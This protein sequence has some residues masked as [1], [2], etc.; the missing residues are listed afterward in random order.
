MVDLIIPFYNEEKRIAFFKDTLQSYLL[1]NQYLDA[2]TMVNDGSKDQTQ[3]MLEAAETELSA[4]FPN[5]TFKVIH[6][7][8]N[9]GKGNAIRAGVLDSNSK[10]VLSSDADFSTLPEQLDNWI[11]LGEV[12]LHHS[13]TTYIASRELG[14]EQEMVRALWHRRVIGRVFSAIVYWFTGIT[15]SDTQCGF[16]LYPTSIAKAAFEPLV[17]LGYA[18][19]V[20]VLFRILKAGHEVQS[21]AVKWEERGLSK[22]N[23]ISDSFKMLVAIVKMRRYV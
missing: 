13:Q 2:V 5:I 4:Q 15:E 1:K 11:A 16:K 22:V 10:W 17:E 6:I 23:L 7:S 3:Q 8:P 9:A 12:D 18:H 20:E 21:L 19:D 14:R